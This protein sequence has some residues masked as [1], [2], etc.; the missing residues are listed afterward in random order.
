MFASAARRARRTTRQSER[1]R[2]GERGRAGEDASRRGKG[3]TAGGNGRAERVA[4]TARPTVSRLRQTRQQDR[5]P[6]LIFT[7]FN[8]AMSFT[9]AATA[10][11]GEGRSKGACARN[12]LA[13]GCVEGAATTTHATIESQQAACGGRR[14]RTPFA[15]LRLGQRLPRRHG[16]Q[17]FC[18]QSSY[19][20]RSIAIAARKGRIHTNMWEFV[21]WARR[22]LGTRGPTWRSRRG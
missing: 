18:R 21:A 1:G 20:P 14:K 22:S 19:P 15:T 16:L 9:G 17:S 10:S 7:R 13:C 4:K 3:R 5:L 12:K 11:Q 6:D 2:E 8:R